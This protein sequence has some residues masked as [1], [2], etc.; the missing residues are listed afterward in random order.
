MRAGGSASARRV[1]EL[2]QAL[3]EQP[4]ALDTACG[5]LRT[6]AHA[7]AAHSPALLEVLE[8]LNLVAYFGDSHPLGRCPDSAAH[9]AESAHKNP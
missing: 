8:L 1:A 3:R 9:S 5:R 4:A 6:Q 2:K 7:S